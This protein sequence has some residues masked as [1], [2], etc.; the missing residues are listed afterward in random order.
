LLEVLCLE[1]HW[2]F[3]RAGP[4]ALLGDY[5]GVFA[6]LGII[7]LEWATDPRVRHSLG[8]EEQGDTL[9]DGSLALVTSIVFLFTR[10]LWLCLA[11]HLGLE[12][13]LLAILGG[14][15]RVQRELTA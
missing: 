11:V 4:L 13:G 7:L 1:V 5:W 15:Y 14:I 8:T 6:G 10:N 3:Y 12:I 9:W 2:A